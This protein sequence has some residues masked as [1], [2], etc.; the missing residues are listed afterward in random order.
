MTTG[1]FKYA[2][3]TMN[4]PSSN[5][6]G[7][8]EMA[9]LIHKTRCEAFLRASTLAG[10]SWTSVE[11]PVG[12]GIQ[13]VYTEEIN[14][15]DSDK[16]TVH[17]QDYTPSSVNTTNGNG[18]N[19]VSIFKK[20][21]TEYMI[22]TGDYQYG[23]GGA[24]VRIP[25]R[26]TLASS[27]RRDYTSGCCHAF[28]ANGF[29]NYDISS[30]IDPNTDEL[31]PMSCFCQGSTNYSDAR[32]NPFISQYG[33]SYTYTFGYAIKDDTFIAIAYS[34]YWGTYGCKWCII[35]KIFDDNVEH[36][37]G[38]ILGPTYN[39]LSWPQSP[40]NFIVNNA[41]SILTIFQVLDYNGKF[42]PSYNKLNAITHTG[43]PTYYPTELRSD[44]TG[45]MKFGAL[46]IIFVPTSNNTNTFSVNA[47]GTNNKGTI[48]TDILRVIPCQRARVDG[49]LFKGGEFITVGTG[50]DTSSNLS[51]GICLGW[52]PSN[53]SLY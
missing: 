39:E 11:V 41:S 38:C 5:Y 52:D 29:S 34:S 3:V 24:G 48:S 33:Y 47:D 12:G 15:S 18:I 1:G 9:K 2:R 16:L 49:S 30:D 46:Q 23:Y 31:V 10:Q 17:V 4:P 21:T 50:T 13:S 22:I 36:P 35:G 43:I 40:N 25:D 8:I 51:V 14:K 6:G 19:F 20:G 53:P 28:A 26:K 32:N 37:Y 42:Y 7:K 44:Y 45:D 27:Y